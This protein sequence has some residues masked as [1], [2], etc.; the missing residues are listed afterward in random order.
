MSDETNNLTSNARR[1]LVLAKEE[2]QMLRNK[3]CGTEHIL[4]GLINMGDTLVSS[5]LE[6]FEVDMDELR[7]VIYD[8]ISQEGN[9]PVSIKAITLTPRVNRVIK[10]AESFAAKLERDKVDVE[11]LFLGLL[12]ESDGVGNSVL[13]SFGVDFDQVKREINKELG[14]VDADDDKKFIDK[15]DQEVLNL[16][17]LQ[18][19][20]IDLTRLAFRKKLGKF[21]GRETEVE[22]VIRILC[23][24]TKNNPVLIGE[25]GVGKTAIIE[26]L[27]QRIVDGNVPETIASKHVFSLDLAGMVAG[28]KYRGQFEERLTNVIKEVKRNKNIILFIDEMHL[29][30]G[31]GSAEGSM[32]AANILKPALA[33]GHL[34]CIGATTPDEFRNS[35]ENDGALDRRFQPVKVKEPTVADAIKILRGIKKEFEAFHNVKYEDKVIV[36]AVNLSKRY[37]TDRFL[38][39]KA[40][41]IIDELGAGKHTTVKKYTDLRKQ[42]QLAEQHGQKKESLVKGQQFEEASKYRDKERDALD[43]VMALTSEIKDTKAKPSKITE[44][45]VEDVITGMTGIPVRSDK[46]AQK[47]VLNLHKT[48][49]KEVIGQGDA[50]VSVSDSLKRSVV[51]INDPGRPVGSFLFLGCTGV[52]KTHLSKML[53]ENMFGSKED[54]VQID[55]SEMMEPH[56]VSKL[57]GAPPGYVGYGKGGKLTEYIRKNPYSLVLFDEVEKAHPDVLNIL[58]QILEEGKITDSNGRSINFRN[59]VVVMTTNVGAERIQQPVPIGFSGGSATQDKHKYVEERALDEVKKHFKPEFLNRIDDLIV[60]NN[61][62]KD[63]LEKIVHLNFKDYTKR[64]QN[65]HK[66]SLKLNKSA[67]DLILEKGYDE[68]FG[69]REINRTIKKLFETRYATELLSGKI[70]E[71]STV[72]IGARAKKLTLTVTKD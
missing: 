7:H 19:F 11:H 32:D 64:A 6:N 47:K 58:L 41:D 50:I 14:R 25:P 48:L 31:A 43:Q 33:R 26:G 69:A 40:I 5:V 20:G 15:D 45:D 72:S 66:V 55:M 28:T 68:K 44:T 2:A 4:L 51:G 18:K 35:I 21:I 3:Y 29:I 27:A 54:I 16:K 38:P 62:G 61:L 24:K 71:G 57:I 9:D 22:R 60:F 56:S 30:V 39:D 37:I 12:Y 59:T 70:P 36:K 46:D 63:Q 23:R 17:N 1:A 67:I 8:N 49:S 13:R 10:R 52:G 65:Q 42:K 53:A 34:R